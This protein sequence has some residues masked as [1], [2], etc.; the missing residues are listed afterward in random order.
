MSTKRPLWDGTPFPDLI[1]DLPEVDIPIS[2]VRGWLLQG[3]DK[4][5]VF[6]DIDTNDPLPEHSHG[7]Q[8]GLVLVGEMDLTI[9]GETQRLGP[10][11]WYFIPDGAVHTA[12]FHGRF[13]VIDFFADKDR[14]KVKG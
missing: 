6:F 2:G 1:R 4:Q 7:E 3:E 13:Q 14:Y 5:M 11:D 8:W 10:G 12:I 9:S